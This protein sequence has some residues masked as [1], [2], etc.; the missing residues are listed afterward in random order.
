MPEAA[1]MAAATA[2]GMGVETGMVAARAAR[3]EAAVA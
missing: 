2:M 3:I 1:A